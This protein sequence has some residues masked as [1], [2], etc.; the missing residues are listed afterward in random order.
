[1]HRDPYRPE[2]ADTILS[3]VPPDLEE[4]TEDVVVT[5][6]EHLDLRVE[7]HRDG[8]RY[9]MEFRPRA[10]VESL[11]GV[12]V[13]ASYL[14]TFDRE[15]AVKD[16]SIDFFASGQPFVEGILAF[17]E[18]NPMGRVG[19]LHLSGEEGEEGFGLLAIYKTGRS[20]EAVAIDV[21]G[22]ERQ[23]WAEKLTQRPLKSRR[24]KRSS[25]TGQPGWSKLIRSLA[26]HLESK[27][28]PEALAAFRIGV[29]S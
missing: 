7:S 8:L 11:P 27:G 19:L 5:T 29:R 22:R 17:L 1:L 4:L 20:F 12:P 6:A 24:V 18:D 3:R 16:E 23:D 13:G 26:S 15:E 21:N 10:K 14:G 25:W 28:Q 9:S 2:L